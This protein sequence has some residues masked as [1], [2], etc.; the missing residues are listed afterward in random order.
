MYRKVSSSRV[1]KLFLYSILLSI[2]GMLIPIFFAFIP[3]MYLSEMRRQGTLPILGVFVGVCVVTGLLTEPMMGLTLLT[4]MGPL[5]LIMDYC[6]RTDRSVKV[7]M[8]IGTFVFVASCGFVLYRSG[9][10]QALQSGEFLK[11]LGAIQ[12]EVVKNA[13][14]S[15]VEQGRVMSQLKTVVGQATTLFPAFLVL[16]GVVMSYLSYR[17]SGR[18]IQLAGEK[19]VCPGPF[20]FM[21]LPKAPVIASVIILAVAYAVSASAAPEIGVYVNNGLVII[22]GLLSF[23]GLSIVNFFLLRYVRSPLVRGLIMVL[24][25]TIPVGQMGLLAL[26]LIDQFIDIRSIQGVQ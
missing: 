5:I 17:I 16:S 23:Q 22:L 24:V 21:K 2:V 1:I 14:L 26:G 8:A 15:E 11:D 19:V 9:M 20:P 12:Q 3:A 4:I 18:N 7:T 13:N 25:F 6:M 10:L